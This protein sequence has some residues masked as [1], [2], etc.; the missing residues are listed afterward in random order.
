M[1][2]SGVNTAQNPQVQVGAVEPESGYL[3]LPNNGSQLQKLKYK[4][5]DGDA[6]L[7][8][9]DEAKKGRYKCTTCNNVFDSYQALGGHRASHSKV[10]GCFTQIEDE[11][12]SLEEQ[13]TDEELNTGLDSQLPHNFHKSLPME[14]TKD[15]CAKAKDETRTIQ[16]ASFSGKKTPRVHECS[17]CHRGFASGQALG[18]HKRCHWVS[19]GAS[20]SLTTSSSN[21]ETPVQQQLLPARVEL[22]DLNLPAP[23]DDDCDAGNLNNLG[24]NTVDSHGASDAQTLSPPYLLSWLMDN[25]PKQGLFLYNNYSHLSKDDEADSKVGKDSGFRRGYDSEFPVTAQSWLQL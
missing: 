2:A 20:D 4:K 23:V 13:I 14:R 7:N 22:L 18:G 5:I 24:G 1:L 10:K 25:Y 19:A 3:K 9:D 8:D 6:G 21:K 16:P 17:I 12:E 15:S 11:N